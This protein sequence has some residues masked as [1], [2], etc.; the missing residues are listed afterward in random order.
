MTKDTCSTVRDEIQKEVEQGWLYP[1]QH[2]KP[3]CIATRF[4]LPQANKVRLIDDFSINGVN[5]TY[6]LREKLRVQSIDEL[7]SYIAFMMDAPLKPSEL[8][9][10]GRTF[11]L[12][13]AYRQLGVDSYHHKLLKIAVKKPGGTYELFKVGA[14]PF[15]AVGSVTAFLRVSNCLAFIASQALQLVLTAFFDDFTVVCSEGEEESATSLLS[16][17]KRFSEC[18]ASGL[19]IQEVKP[20]LLHHDSRLWACSFLLRI[21]RKVSSPW[22]IRNPE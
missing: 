5:A 14:H 2:G 16:V 20:H 13:H 19:R 18:L 21:C 3:E 8:K 7:C 6:G 9:L 1:S 22:N 15:G 4:P 10:T 17:W 11:D 12:K